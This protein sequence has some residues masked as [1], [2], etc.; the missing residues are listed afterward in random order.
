MLLMNVG[1]SAHPLLPS[2]LSPSVSLSP[3]SPRSPHTAAEE[4]PVGNVTAHPY[5]SSLRRR[6]RKLGCKLRVI[7][8]NRHVGYSGLQS[9]YLFFSAPSQRPSHDLLPRNIT[10]TLC[11][12]TD[13]FLYETFGISPLEYDSIHELIYFCALTN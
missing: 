5:A 6:R 2:S 8:L 3:C 10:L 4:P 12:V 7:S 13:C 11:S 9:Q 1:P